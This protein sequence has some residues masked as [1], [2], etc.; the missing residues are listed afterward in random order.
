MLSSLGAFAEHRCLIWERSVDREHW[1]G[2]LRVP[3]WVPAGPCVLRSRPLIAGESQELI[4]RYRGGVDLG[5]DPN[6]PD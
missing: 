5:S 2:R 4:V 3:V 1:R 6:C